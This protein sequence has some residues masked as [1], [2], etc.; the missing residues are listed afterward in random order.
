[1]RVSALSSMMLWM[2]KTFVPF[3]YLIIPKMRLAFFKIRL[4]LGGNVACIS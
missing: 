2:N 4:A 1:M 3:V